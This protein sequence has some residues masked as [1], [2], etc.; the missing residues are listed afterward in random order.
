VDKYEVIWNKAYRRL[1]RIKI[2]RDKGTKRKRQIVET[3][4]GGIK[5]F[6]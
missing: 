4:R 5:G 6:Y 1:E 3:C 2:S